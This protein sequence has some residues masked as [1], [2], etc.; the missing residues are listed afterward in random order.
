MLSTGKKRRSN[1]PAAEQK[2]ADIMFRITCLI[3]MMFFVLTANVSADM[4][5]SELVY[6]PSVCHAP[7]GAEDPLDAALQAAQSAECLAMMAAFPQPDLE[8]IPPDKST[9]RRSYW[10]LEKRGTNLYD[11]PGGQL[12]GNIPAGFNFVQATDAQVEGW[13]QREGGEWLRSSDGKPEHP[14]NFVG[15]AL[16]DNWR[17][18]FAIIVDK[19][20]KYASTRPGV[21]GSRDSGFFARRHRLVNIFARAEDHMGKVWYLVGPQQWIRQ[22]LVAMFAPAQQPA[23][24]SGHWVAVDL[25]EQTLIAYEDDT[26]VFATVVSSGLSQWP[27]VEGLFKVWARLRKDTMSGA[28]GQPDAYYVQN[29]PWVMYFKGGISLH[30]TYWHDDFGYRRSHGCVNLSISDARWIY[31]WMLEAEPDEEGEII[32]AVYVFSSGQY[33]HG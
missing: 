5:S 28:A 2:G 18:P 32:N 21:F 8:R 14:S 19:S 30:G 4:T 13:L 11:T 6:D 31:D 9:L 20:G 25:F 27:T 29:V 22:E 3:L 16:P 26:P 23:D 1:S 24:V 33:A 7:D 15:F 10:R 17:H 12:I